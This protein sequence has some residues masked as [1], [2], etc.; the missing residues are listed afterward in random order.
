MDVVVG[1]AIGAIIGAMA[2]L[3]TVSTLLVNPEQEIVKKENIENESARL[4]IIN[5]GCK[6]RQVVC[7]Y[8]Y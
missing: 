7:S 2:A 6:A 8:E 1:G 3:Q 5:I 4:K